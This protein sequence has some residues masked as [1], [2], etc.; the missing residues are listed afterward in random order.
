MAFS[1]PKPSASCQSQF[2]Q[3]LVETRGGPHQKPGRIGREAD[4]DGAVES[5]VVPDAKRNTHPKARVKGHGT[6]LARRAKLPPV[7]EED[8]RHRAPVAA[9]EFKGLG[10]R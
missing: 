1:P 5:E 10:Q 3:E 9:A 2:L 4:H 7:R 8:R 6:W